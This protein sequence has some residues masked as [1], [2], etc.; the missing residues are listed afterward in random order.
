MQLSL[1]FLVTMASLGA[2][3]PAAAPSDESPPAFILAGD[4]T[5]AIQSADGGGWG[6]GFLSFLLST[7]WGVDLGHNGA[8]TVSF[9]DGGDWANVT[10]L[11]DTK[12]SDYDVYVTIQFGHNDQVCFPSTRGVVE[13]SSEK[14]TA[15]LRNR[16]PAY[17]RPNTRPTCRT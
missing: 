10:G 7:A 12:K 13:K 5:T 11:I 17:R 2:A 14:L 15:E 3:A 4:S 16:R 6:V 9:V 8:T 1:S